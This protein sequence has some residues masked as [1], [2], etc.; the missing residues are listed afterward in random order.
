MKTKVTNLLQL[1]RDSVASGMRD[2]IEG[3]DAKIA[4]QGTGTR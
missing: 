3:E 1:I 4:H 2:A